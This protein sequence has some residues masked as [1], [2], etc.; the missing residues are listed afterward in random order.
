MQRRK[1]STKTAASNKG[2]T[3]IP[4][5]RSASMKKL[6]KA[7]LAGDKNAIRIAEAIQK[8]RTERNVPH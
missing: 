3:V 8:V 1:T 2:Q 7:T 4:A 6:V 5:R